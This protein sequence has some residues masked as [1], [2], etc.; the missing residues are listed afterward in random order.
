MKSLIIVV[1]LTGCSTR[2][3]HRITQ[4]DINCTTCSMKVKYDVDIGDE[5]L[6]IKGF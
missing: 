4:Y 3:N 6:E 5:N 2:G 1:L